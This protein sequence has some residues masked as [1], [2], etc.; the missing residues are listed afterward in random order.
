MI[1]GRVQFKHVLCLALQHVTAG[2]GWESFSVDTGEERME[3]G[4]NQRCSSKLEGSQATLLMAI[5][6]G[7]FTRPKNMRVSIVQRN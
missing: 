5:T 6:V 3:S 1:G 2:P 7:Q 4:S